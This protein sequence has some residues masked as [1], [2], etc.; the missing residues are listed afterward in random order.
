MLPCNKRSRHSRKPF[1]AGQDA[2]ARQSSP[3]QATS[4]SPPLPPHAAPHLLR[5]CLRPISTKTYPR[6]LR[7]SRPRHSGAAAALRTAAS[8]PY[9]PSRFPTFSLVQRSGL[10]LYR[11]TSTRPST[12]TVALTMLVVR[13]SGGRESLQ[14]STRLRTR[15]RSP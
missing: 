2:P 9:T 1:S 8:H 3:L 15:I 7:A 6:R 14:R 4:Q 11:R 5:H 10:P 12:P 13:P